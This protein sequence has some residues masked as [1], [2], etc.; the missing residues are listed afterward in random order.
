MTRR[1]VL[2]IYT[3]GTIGMIKD[4]KTGTL[5]PFNFEEILDR[6]PELNHLDC[7]VETF[8]FNNPIDS[9]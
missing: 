3:G 6:M 8:T 4:K 2:L 7:D 1:T 9:S 5:I